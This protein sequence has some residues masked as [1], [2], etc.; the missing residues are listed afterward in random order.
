KQSPDDPKILMV[1]AEIDAYLGQGDAAMREARRALELLPPQKDAIDGARIAAGLARVA[2]LAGN[3]E[4]ALDAFRAAAQ[5][6]VA[7]YY[8]Q[9]LLDP[10]WDPLRKDAAFAEVLARL[11][12]KESAP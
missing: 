2:V 12:P 1:A 5:Y 11:T 4:E 7:F 8:G 10:V 6:P 3:H 9:L